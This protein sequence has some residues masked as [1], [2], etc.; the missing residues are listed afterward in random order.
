MSPLRRPAFARLWGAA[1]CSEIAEW[2]LQVSLP[3]LIYTATGSAT[4]TAT[5]MV[6]G[7]LPTVV[8]GPAAGVLADC[9]N[10]RLV[11]C[12]VCLAQAAV[13]LPLLTVRGA[14]DGFL[15][16]MVMAAQAG[17]AAF[18]EPA[19]NALIPELVEPA[20]L[21]A[22]N[23]LMGVNSNL[24]RLVGASAGG[25]LL[26]VGGIGLVLAGYLVAALSAL[27]LLLPGTAI[28]RRVAA[29]DGQRDGGSRRA[30]PREWLDGIAEVGRNRTLRVTAI[31]Y[32]VMS[33]AQGMF[34]VL[35]VLFALDALGGTEGDVGLLRGVQA[36][37]GLAAG[38][39]L[40]TIGRHVGP[41]ALLGWG[42]TTLG[43][44]SALIWNS[45][46][47]TD[48][49]GIYVVLFA[50]VGIPGVVAGSGLLSVL[51]TST[52]ESLTG[53][54]MG[55]VLAGGAAWQ[56]A[57]MLAAGSLVGVLGLPAVLNLQAG[58]HVLAGVIVFGFLVGALPWRRAQPVRDQRPACDAQ[59]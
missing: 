37:G 4:S 38:I 23:A 26:G 17:L 57:G 42:A 49:I 35:F 5:T 41:R 52:A 48:R 2:I 15:V 30:L 36:V 25:L 44:S 40:A 9:W 16:Y 6:L 3:L 51:Q 39:A 19:R 29:S 21:T 53:R 50:L 20:Q 13:A 34:L 45:A 47:F 43:L 10:R 11:L 55:A 58:L 56:A 12:L 7:L 31:M 27:V 28:R 24:A 22:A 8:V 46:Q 33:V 14:G 32:S 54:V 18:F 1:F 59:R